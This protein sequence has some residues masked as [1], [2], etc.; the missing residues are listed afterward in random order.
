MT[1][2]TKGLV[3]GRKTVLA[4]A[5]AA[6]GSLSVMAH[7]FVPK[8]EDPNAGREVVRA[9]FK[10]LKHAQRIV[11]SRFETLESK[12]ETGYL[13][14][15]ANATERAELESLGYRIEADPQ[16]LHRTAAM[17][18][19]EA[20]AADDATAIP[21]FSCY[22]TVEE[23]FAAAQALVAS[24][25]TLAS[26]NK[27]GESWQKTTGA[28]GYD[29]MVL[30]LTN[31]AIGGSKPK[32]F[33]NSAIHAR[34][35]ATAPLTL[36][37]A[38]HLINGYGTDPDAT[39]LLDHHEVHLLLQ[40]NPDGRKKA[41][42][43]ILWRKNTNTAYCG[44]T[45]NSRG[46]DLNRNFTYQWNST[47]GSGS[48]GS[49]CS[50]VYRGPS[51]ASEPE[52]QAVERYIR[53]LWPD[54]R[55][56]NRGDP[57]PLD[58]SGIHLDIHSHGRLLLWPYG[59]A[60][61]VA[62]NDVQ[63]ATLGRKFA[64]FNN[65]TPQRSLDLY[66]TDGTS[67]GPSYGE[68]GVAAFTFELGTAFFESCSYYNSTLL[69]TNLPALIYAAKVVR[70]PYQT[71]AGPDALGVAVSSG[72]VG[73]GT[74][75]TLTAQ[76]DDTRYNNSNGTEPTQTVAAAEYYVDT[77]PW[78]AGAVAR[79]MNA[80]DGSFNANKEN[81]TASINTSGWS[82]GKHLIY[83]RGRDSAGNWG[84]FS[85]V[86]V[87]ISAGGTAPV[88]R[89]S[90]TVSGL[91]AS[92]TDQSTDDG[93]ITA[94]RWEFGDGNTSTATN[95]SHTYASGGTYNVRLTV[96]DNDGLTA[97]TT[98]P[99]T[100]GL[101][102]AITVVKGQPISNISDVR[103]G[104]KYFKVNV[105]AGATNLSIAISGGTGDADLYTRPGAK[106]DLSTYTCRPYRSGN[107]ETCSFATPPA[108]WYY[109]GIRGYSAYSGVRLT[110][111]YTGG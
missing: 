99:V 95:P 44:A 4:L 31:S 32:L 29:L 71:P 87:N 16:W 55:G 88:A 50:E 40:T 73:P 59:T 34:E 21:G 89:F 105:P 48:S 42:T 100:V 91:S 9:Y 101:D 10:D 85:A 52:T 94:R 60:G 57:A 104:W 46:A 22:E 102:D 111:N 26:W 39:W 83:V 109:I 28:G 84:A 77:P 81:V 14:V 69:P 25:P 82:A 63:L 5:V 3:G 90:H 37:F 74:P 70:T 68:L 38:K 110:V 15:N 108:G 24:R 1:K 78:V 54:R 92:F 65:H 72:T 20:S 62:P 106:P 51:A 98:T 56:P 53:S 2:A 27:I 30:K 13:I 36:A 45:S 93:S 58:T 12:Y 35:Y 103:N 7:D 43:G 79:P 97:S 11:H 19:R 33:I 107:S 8:S 67:D 75:V 80:A 41:E 17:L 47:G 76:I 66:E 23:S 96:T 86:F 6:L 18:A 64:F 61:S 49:G